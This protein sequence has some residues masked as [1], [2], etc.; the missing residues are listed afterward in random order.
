MVRM[1]AVAALLGVACGTSLR[2]VQ[3]PTAR[4]LDDPK[5]M[6]LRFPSVPNSMR[7]FL[8]SAC[9]GAAGV[10]CLAP[11][12]ILRLSFMSKGETFKGA[13]ASLGAP[14]M[15]F[16]GNKADTLSTALKIGI[17]M[18]AFALYKNMITAVSGMPEDAPT[19]RWAVFLAGAL[20]GCTATCLCY[21]LDVVRMRIALDTM[22]ARGSIVSCLGNICS[23]EGV[24]A[25]YF[26]LPATIAGIIPFSSM[27]LAT[28]DLLRR[29]LTEGV[30]AASVS[31]SLAQSAQIGAMAGIVAATSCFPFEVVRRRQMGGELTS[32]SVIGAMAAIANDEGLSAL[33]KGVS[34]NV[35]KVAL[36]NSLGFALYENFK[37]VLQ[38]DNRKPP[39]KRAS[40]APMHSF[41]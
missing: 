39:W 19:P 8:A 32:L 21:P 3:K 9:S 41:D 11:V 31:V 24:R 4:T 40:I 34:I 33:F 27:K 23:N 10:T 12:E 6:P 15:W 28:Y 37:D 16:R 26:G 22:P 38:V 1:L 35:F 5:M 30:D 18:P 29:R 13:V 14:Q 20:A 36:S 17:T 7:H 2:T 25:L